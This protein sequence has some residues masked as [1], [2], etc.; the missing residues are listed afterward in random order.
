MMN[1]ENPLS[2][3]ELD[4]DPEDLCVYGEDPEG[5]SPFE[6]SDNIVVVLPINIDNSALVESIM[7]EAVDPL[8]QSDEM[9]VDIYEKA[10]RHVVF[11]LGIS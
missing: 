3:G 6:N 8:K 9:G 11:R 4:N 7:L 1:P 2:H 10:L 5:P